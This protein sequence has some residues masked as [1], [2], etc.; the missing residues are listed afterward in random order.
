MMAVDVYIRLSPGFSYADSER[1]KIGCVHKPGRF[2]RA[3]WEEWEPDQEKSGLSSE[4][5]P[6]DCY[7]CV[8]GKKGKPSELFRKRKCRHEVH[9]PS[10]SFICYSRKPNPRYSSSYWSFYCENCETRRRYRVF[11]GY[12]GTQL[13]E[14]KP[15][16]PHPKFIT[17][18]VDD[19]FFNRCQRERVI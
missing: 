11:E 12:G 6:C 18:K 17:E 15:G 19:E 13:L 14:K 2:S 5:T 3:E 7:M 8:A 10:K 4:H 1:V 9:F 16:V